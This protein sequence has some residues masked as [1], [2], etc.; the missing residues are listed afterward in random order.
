MPVVEKFIKPA[1]FKTI[2]NKL[3][4]NGE[5]VRIEYSGKQL[6]KNTQIAEFVKELGLKKPKVL[7]GVNGRGNSAVAGITVKDGDTVVLRAAGGV[8][9]TFG[10]QP[11]IQLRGRVGTPAEG[12]GTR[13]NMIADL[14]KSVDAKN[15]AVSMSNKGG[16]LDVSVDSDMLSGN[17][18]ADMNSKEMRIPQVKRAYDKMMQIMTDAINGNKGVKVV[19]EK[20]AEALNGIK[21][22]FGK[23]KN[24]AKTAVK[25]IKETKIEPKEIKDDKIK[26]FVKDLQYKAQKVEEEK[27]IAEDMKWKQLKTDEDCTFLLDKAK[28]LGIRFDDPEILKDPDVIKRFGLE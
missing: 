17:F 2:G 28:K 11:L 24:Y 21:D 7:V 23:V 20:T 5:R 14:N 18:K 8:D 16:K 27:K 10:E 13:L 15:M 4:Q 26:S 3:I 22:P 19:K 1:K 25:E 6:Q 12:E 9:Y